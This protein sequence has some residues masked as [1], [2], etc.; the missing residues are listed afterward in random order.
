MRIEG[1]EK[2]PDGPEMDEYKEKRKLYEQEFQNVLSA[3]SGGSSL[4]PI[5]LEV[6]SRPV[7]DILTETLTSI[8]SKNK[9]KK[10]F[11]FLNWSYFN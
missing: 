1:E 7:E 9:T 8:E 3:I 4:D 11:S 2:V 10:S 6:E 5:S